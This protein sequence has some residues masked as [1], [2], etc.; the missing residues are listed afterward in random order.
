MHA[1]EIARR[2]GDRADYVDASLDDDGD[3]RVMRN[4]FGPGDYETEVTAIVFAKDLARLLEALQA[5]AHRPP[6]DAAAQADRGALL[7][8]LVKE[9]YD[10]NLRAVED[11]TSFARSKGIE[12]GWFR[13]P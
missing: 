8:Q 2:T 7:L 10:G 3:L 12:V 5:A 1:V 11:F 9:R 6:P 4:S 13:W